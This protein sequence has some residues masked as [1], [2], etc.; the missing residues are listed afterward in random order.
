[1]QVL[2]QALINAIK[3]N[4]KQA[5]EL[6]KS[7]V[8]DIKSDTK[9]I[10][11]L[12]KDVIARDIQE[13]NIDVKN[14]QTATKALD[15]LF[16]LV[17]KNEITKPQALLQI[18]KNPIFKPNE[19][20]VSNI[21][22][23][24]KLVQKEPK[25]SKFVKPLEDFAKHI[26]NVDAKNLKSQVKLSGVG[27][28]SK[29]SSFVKEPKLPMPIKEALKQLIDEKNLQKPQEQKHQILP[30]NL[31]EKKIKNLVKNI[32]NVLQ[33]KEVFKQD[34]KEIRV[35]IVE[36]LKDL[37]K[38]SKANEAGFKIIHKLEQISEKLEMKNSEVKVKNPEAKPQIKSDIK[39]PIKEVLKTDAKVETKIENPKN[40]QNPQD[41][42]LKIQE[43][44][45]PLK[46]S[47]QIKLPTQDDNVKIKNNPDTQ[48]KDL[49]VKQTVNMNM[50]NKDNA[51]NVIKEVQ[52]TVQKNE[53]TQN[54]TVV[55]R[56]IE[57][58]KRPLV[59]VAKEIKLVL[60]DIKQNIQEKTSKLPSSNVQEAK[61]IIKEIENLVK[62]YEQSVQVATTKTPSLNIKAI[63]ENL[64]IEE[65][66][67]VLTSRIKQGIE[68]EQKGSF[69]LNEGKKI[70]KNSIKT[71]DK[72]ISNLPHEQSK[73][74][75]QEIESDIKQ[76]LM[77]LKESPTKEI[78]NMSNKILTNI[79]TNQFISFA[80]NS[81]NTYV[82]YIWEG[83]KEGSISFKSGKDE[84]FFCQIDLDLKVYG[85]VNVMI[86]LTNDSYISINLSAQM[87]SLKDKLDEN[88]LELKKAL[89]KV[90]LL[91]LHVNVKPYEPTSA[92]EKNAHNQYSM[93]VRI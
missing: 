5:K 1:M 58:E 87:Q 55:T 62:I 34:I 14:L 17:S 76:T 23:L 8:L 11:N 45:E 90:G 33:K 54:P 12:S 2:N 30:Q 72:H 39:E 88:I 75:K 84:S 81:I 6:I 47:V 82:P 50:Q 59:K 38:I 78:S 64:N 85:K 40:T 4:P 57:S 31:S 93:N 56:D 69:E 60:E 25:L 73:F 29:I 19:P 24:V 52:T 46:P 61:T 13:K 92:Y 10:E 65:K 42:K 89:N 91:P 3:E 41:I 21:K 22:E 27:F 36:A 67:K 32:S 86:M 83:L 63:P 77:K 48:Y 37:P 74:S 43:K 9:S 68:L 79:E 28:E 70:L 80:N 66:I 26:S 71:I 53:I 20:I 18:Q 49:H 35:N 15:K 7:S 51:V 16:S 44:N